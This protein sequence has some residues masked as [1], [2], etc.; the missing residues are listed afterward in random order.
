M[1]NFNSYLKLFL[2]AISMLFVT[3]CVHDEKYDVPN[4]GEYQC[5][6]LKATKTLA[7]LKA[8]PQNQT[9]TSDD[10]IE[11]YVS[12]SDETGNIYKYIY[13]QDKPENPTQ[14]LVVSVNA[15]NTY[16]NYP[17]GAK[18]YIK[19]KDLALGTYGDFIQLGAMDNTNTFGRIPEKLLPTNFIKSC[20]DK[21]TIVPKVMT[22]SEVNSKNEALVGAL[23][24]INNAEFHAETL[25]T[26]YAPDGANAAKGLTDATH[27]AKSTKVAYNSGYSTFASKTLPSGN[28]TFIGILS[29]YRTT[30]QFLIVRDSDLTM[31]GKRLDGKVAPCVADAAATKMTVAQVKSLL[32]GSKTQITQNA[33]LTGIITANDETGNIYRAFYIQDATGGIKVNVNNTSLYTDRRFQ[34][35]RTLT[36]NLKDLYLFDVNDELQLGLDNQYKQIESADMYLYFFANE[37]PVTNVVATEKAISSLTKDDVGKWVKIKDLQFIDAD[38]YKTYADGTATTNR[39]LQDCNGNT[40]LLRTSGRADFGTKDFPLPSNIIEID[41]G[42]GDVYGIL[43]IYNGTY[44]LWITKLRDIDL[45]NPR[46]DGTLPSKMNYTEIFKDEFADL[47]NWKAISVTGAEVWST[48]TYGN[49]KPSAIMDGKRLLNEDWLVSKSISLAG[50]TDAFLSFDTDGRYTGSTFEV[51]VTENFTGTPSTTTWTKLNP[52]L[53]TDLNAFAGFINSGNVSL[54][55]YAGKNVVIAFKYTSVAGASTTW[56]LDNVTVKGTK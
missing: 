5:G 13:I 37:N 4:L 43:S 39:T 56:E 27:S 41:P 16:L 45:D 38:L 48:T 47:S 17:Q 1:K 3:G 42:K 30:Y 53:D 54:K 7:E 19:L 25:C 9:F 15:V 31:T 40:I 55:N 50:Y 51:Y 10:V 34:V 2:I 26:Q 28:G 32:T 33:T 21:Q 23:I 8:M 20:K 11:G 12:S 52:I 36:I 18:V 22:L 29:K 44:Q 6:E 35:G 46:C 49:P 24:Q 14:G